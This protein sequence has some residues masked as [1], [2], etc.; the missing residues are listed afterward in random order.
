[1]T[2]IQFL[3]QLNMTYRKLH[4]SYENHFRR[5]YMW[6]HSQDEQMNTAQK[7]VDAFRSSSIYSAKI[8]AY[9]QNLED[10]SMQEELKSR[11]Q[12]RAYFFSL[13]QVPAEMQA[14]KTEIDTYETDLQQRMA[15]YQ[16]QKSGYIDPNS[17]EF[18]Q[19]SGAQM[20]LHIQTHDDENMRRACR[21]GW[22]KASLEFVDDL[23]RLVKKRNEYARG[24]GY[25]DFYELKAVTEERMWSAEIFELFDSIY[26]SLSPNLTRMRE[27]EKTKPGVREPW[28]MSYMMA[29]DF[30]KQEDQYFPLG[31]MVDVWGRSMTALWVDY[32]G[33]TM[34]LDLLERDGKYNNGFCHQP[35]VWYDQDG[36]HHG[37]ETNFTCN[38]I[39]GQIWAGD[40][41]GNTLFHEWW[42]AAHFANMRHQDVIFNTERAPCSTAW[43]ETQSMFIDTMYSSIEWKSIYAKN[44][45]GDMYPFSLH[46]KIVTDLAPLSGR[47]MLGMASVVKLEQTLYTVCEDQLTPEYICNLVRDINMRYSD[48]KTPSLRLLTIPHIYSRS[49]SAYYHGYAMA[50]LALH[51]FREYIYDRDGYIVDN[52]KIWAFLQQWRAPGSSKS[53]NEL[54]QD[55]IWSDLSPDAYLAQVTLSPSTKIEKSLDRLEMT[56]NKRTPVESVAINATIELRDGKDLIWSSETDG[57]EGMN[58]K[59]RVKVWE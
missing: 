34:R 41:A 18:V 47:S 9:I 40:I 21:E 59:W 15:A 37:W 54:M 51:Q 53:M 33:A 6:D 43:A 52:P 5:S 13:Y 35:V 42:H 7:E 32:A 20:R 3:D 58:E 26:T 24:C 57:R 31:E 29:G 45:N 4:T 19:M 27:V 10:K 50:T 11:L 17:W 1:M 44:V 16:S 49:S 22:E 56:M 23:I 28:N 25:S 30:T 12:W 39:P 55:M 46:E 36:S 48:M 38:A 2:A 14:L 8:H